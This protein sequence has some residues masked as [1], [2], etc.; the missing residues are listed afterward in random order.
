MTVPGDFTG[1]RNALLVAFE[2]SHLIAFPAWRSALRPA[3]AAGRP[4]APDVAG[5]YAIL[6]APPAP[7]WLQQMSVWALQFEVQDPFER[8]H[9]AILHTDLDAWSGEA[10][11]TPSE[12]PLLAVVGADGTVYATAS[13][14][15]DPVKTHTILRVLSHSSAGRP[16]N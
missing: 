2:R 3:L 9:T 5:Y 1:R 4:G 14:F 6:I 7:T 15:P 16:Q 8:D 11:L 12:E 13:G 10:G